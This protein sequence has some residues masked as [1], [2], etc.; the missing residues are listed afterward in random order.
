MELNLRSSI[1]AD[2]VGLCSILEGFNDQS[3]KLES[4]VDK[5]KQEMLKMRRDSEQVMYELHLLTSGHA[6]KKLTGN[7]ICM[8]IFGYKF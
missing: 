8:H 5:L 6:Q 7:T 1:D 4:E 2:A 3:D